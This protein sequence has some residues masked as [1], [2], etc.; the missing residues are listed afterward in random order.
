MCGIAG[1]FVR[2]DADTVDR[3]TLARMTA[4]L[5]H[6]GPDQSGLY[7]GRRVGLASARL[8][9]VGVDGGVQPIGNEDGTLWIVF[10][11]EAFNY[12]ELKDDLR[13]EQDRA[14]HR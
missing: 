13:R 5:R 14:R 12:L 4:A 1:M 8:S 9:I 6:R 2:E 3:D 10:N 7:L 11:G